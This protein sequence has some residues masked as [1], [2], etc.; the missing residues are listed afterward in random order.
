MG[1]TG[2]KSEVCVRAVLISGISRRRSPFLPFPDPRG[3]SHYL[4][5]GLPILSSKPAMAN[6]VF[7]RMHHF[8]TD[9]SVFLF[10]SLR[11]FV[12]ILGMSGYNLDIRHVW[13]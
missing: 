8:D 6:G 3:C 2:L 10:H 5:Y 4:S 11:T 7:L 9:S 13:L 12:V 1:L